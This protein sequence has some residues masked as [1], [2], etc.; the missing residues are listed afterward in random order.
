MLSAIAT[1]LDTQVAALLH[2]GG[3]AEFAAAAETNPLAVPAAYVIA[4]QETPGPNQL[5]NDV[6]QRIVA[7]VGVVLVVRNV[8]DTT[9]AAA[10]ADLK[11]LRAAVQTALLGWQPATG[12]DPLERAAPSG[13]L[14]FKDQHLWW[15]DAYATAY[16]VR[17][18]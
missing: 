2:V 18:Y 9:G 13:L 16:Y 7:H 5:G 17:S 15:Q 8:A 4:L 11:T 12:Y 6:H 3:A 10:Q 1:R 14:A